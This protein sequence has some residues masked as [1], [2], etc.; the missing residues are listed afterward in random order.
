MK[1]ELPFFWC[2]PVTQMMIPHVRVGIP[3]R[4]SSCMKE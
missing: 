3:W 2:L 1:A 4:N